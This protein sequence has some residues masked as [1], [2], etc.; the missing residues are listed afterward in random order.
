MV[1]LEEGYSAGEFDLI[2]PENPGSEA[3]FNVDL[4]LDGRRWA[5]DCGKG[6]GG[7]SVWV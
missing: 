6:G 4:N 5:D 2:N 7:S 3:L 1:V